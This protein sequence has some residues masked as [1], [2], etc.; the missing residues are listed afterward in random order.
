MVE[1]ENRKEKYTIPLREFFDKGTTRDVAC[2][3]ERLKALR[4]AIIEQMKEINAALWSDLRKSEGEAYLTE[5]G[6]VLGEINYHVKHLRQWAKSR[7][8]ATPLAVW[9]SKSWI[10][11]EP[12]GVVLIIAPWNYPFQLLLEPLIGAISAGNCVVLK[13]SPF[14]PATA[15]VI[16]KIVAAVFEPG[17]VS[18]FDG[19]GNVAELL[20]SERFDY[21][22]FTGGSHFGQHVM[23]MAA[24]HL[25]PVTLELGGK[26]P[27]IVGRGANVEIAARRTA[28]GKFIN[29]G[30]TCVAPDYVF[31]HKNQRAEFVEAVRLTVKR[32]YGDRPCDSPDYPRIV[33]RE[34]TERLANLIH[35]SGQVVFGGEV[36]VEERYIAP[37]VL[38]D[39]E[40]DSLIM[41]E[42]I[43][44]PILPV[45]TYREIDDVIRFVNKRDKPLALYYF[46][47]KREAREVL[48]RTSSGGAC[49][50]DTIVHLAN[51]RLPFGGVGMS[52]VGKYH[53]KASFE[54]F[55]NLRSVVKSFTFFD[56]PFRYAPYKCLNLLKRFM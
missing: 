45:L 26:S 19:E 10:M 40:A 22:F 6:M 20:L 30:Q 52:G 1:S 33:H 29:A 11:Y 14:A 48:S 2:R 5:I 23:E 43:F 15:E 24:K 32:F 36:N 37:T 49:V 7:R 17:Y 34:G 46:G 51:P 53:G 13:P 44:G 56:N 28:W 8:Q 38:I 9:P 21:I 16:K 39:V 42:E 55:S 47:P 50:N 27:C 25:T 4:R 3:I 31:V 12:Y 35:A 54:L 18:V 41:R